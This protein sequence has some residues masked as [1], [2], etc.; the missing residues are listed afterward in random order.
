ML[1]RNLRVTEAR[2]FEL[3]HLMGLSEA[4]VFRV[5]KIFFKRLSRL[6]DKPG[7]LFSFLDH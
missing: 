6:R 2:F 5:C 7:V 1:M 4:A 3:N